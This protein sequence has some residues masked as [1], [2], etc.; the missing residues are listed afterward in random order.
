MINFIQ[1]GLVDR[2][3]GYYMIYG[4]IPSIICVIMS[5][6]GFW[7]K[8]SNAPA[9]VALC[10]TTYLSIKTLGQEGTQMNVKLTN[11]LD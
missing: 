10:V 3:L 7:I 9:R 5:W 4:I 8:L 11:L 6:A 1:P 2:K